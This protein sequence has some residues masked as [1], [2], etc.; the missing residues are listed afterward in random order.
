MATALTKRDPGGED[1]RDV[2][3]AWRRGDSIAGAAP[4]RTVVPIAMA[5]DRGTRGGVAGAVEA[6]ETDRVATPR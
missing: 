3:D 6:S 5:L 2:D 1:V 4:P